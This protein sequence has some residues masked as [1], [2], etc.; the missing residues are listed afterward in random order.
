MSYSLRKFDDP[1]LTTRCDPV[2]A[3]DDL[4]FLSEMRRVCDVE[5][6][7]GLAAPQIGVLKRAVFIWPNRKGGEALFMLNP[8]I[9]HKGPVKATENEGCLSYPGVRCPVERFT[10]VRVRYVDE[11]FQTREQQFIYYAA[12]VVQHELDHLD[13]ICRVGEA[14]RIRRDAQPKNGAV[15][16][17]MSMAAEIAAEASK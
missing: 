2:E 3:G 7:V 13:G 1:A 14:W 12:R 10:V 17:A 16:F 6:G 15:A 8:W 9:V 11:Y 5:N 4:S